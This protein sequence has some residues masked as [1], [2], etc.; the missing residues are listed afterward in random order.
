MS[1]FPC[2]GC[3]IV[4]SKQMLQTMRFCECLEEKF[5]FSGGGQYLKIKTEQ[6]QLL[7]PCIE[8]TVD[9]FCSWNV[10]AEVA[11]VSIE[12]WKGVHYFT[13]HYTMTENGTS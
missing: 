7:P 2:A 10:D 6:S 4:S 1:T 3:F 12:Y 11:E 13:V 5:E 9:R 8:N